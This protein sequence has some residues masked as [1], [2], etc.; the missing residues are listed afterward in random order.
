MVILVI[1]LKKLEQNNQSLC[2]L[3]GNKITNEHRELVE[4]ELELITENKMKMM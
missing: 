4:K 1:K 2:K 3:A